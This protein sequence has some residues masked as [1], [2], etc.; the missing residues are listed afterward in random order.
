MEV[1]ELII[2]KGSVAREYEFPLRDEEGQERD[3]TGQIVRI[4]MAD[5]WNRKVYFNL[6]AD[7]I[8]EN[9]ARVKITPEAADI[10]AEGFYDVFAIIGEE[11]GPDVVYAEP[12]KVFNG[13]VQG[14]P[15]VDLSP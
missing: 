3:I 5:H 12:Y 1:P 15:V 14:I 6:E 8:T 7:H 11:S 4:V 10:P 13:Y 2:S 9:P